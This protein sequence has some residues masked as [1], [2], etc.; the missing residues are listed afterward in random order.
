MNMRYFWIR[1]QK[2]FKNFLIEWKAGQENLAESFTKHHSIKHH[3]RACPIYLQTYKTPRTVP[4]VLL[5]PY[6][7]GCVDTADSKMEEFCNTSPITQISQ[8][9]GSR[10]HRKGR[11]TTE[12]CKG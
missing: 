2:T 10:T 6:L 5:K 1:D 12:R 4:L 3:K 9:R 8:L 7:K 11:Q